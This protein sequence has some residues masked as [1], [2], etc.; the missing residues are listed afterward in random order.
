M[1]CVPSTT[2]DNEGVE[3]PFH[4]TEQEVIDV[5]SADY[6]EIEA[7]EDVFVPDELL[8]EEELDA[9]EAERSPTIVSATVDEASGVYQRV[10]SNGVRV[11]YRVTNNEPDLRSLA[12]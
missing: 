8:S 1:A 3:V 7:M 6:G 10:L 11:N 9:L 2:T 12:S 4:I 5:L